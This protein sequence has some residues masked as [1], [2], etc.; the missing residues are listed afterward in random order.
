[1][2]VLVFG[3][4]GQVA[5]ELAR[6]DGVTCLDR[7]QADLTDVEACV[8]QIAATDADVIINAA[9]YTAVDKAETEEALATQI[10][11]TTVTAM[12]KAA[13]ARNLPFLHISTDY[14]FDGAGTAPWQPTDATG[15]IGAYGRSKLTGEQGVTAAG[16][17]HAILRTSW[18]YSAHG[19]N[20]VK[21]MLRLG[22]ERDALSIVSDQIGGPT[23]AH[24]IAAAL[25]KMATQFHTQK[26]QSGIYHFS[27]APDASWQEFAQEI[28]DQSGL[29]VAVAG[30]ATKDYPTPAQRPLNSRMDC[31][32]LNEFFGIER[33]NWR[34]SLKA[35]LAELGENNAET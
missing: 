16:G 30:I 28:F 9:A 14:V 19:N 22:A 34:Q 15:P 4:S 20:F 23:A 31:S 17:P 27:G 35:V 3:K 26:S 6:F 5:T 33:A 12:A 2:R 32:S 21:T 10:N 11:G 7:A 1:M 18:V 29:Q 8:R 25:M 13:A 24:D